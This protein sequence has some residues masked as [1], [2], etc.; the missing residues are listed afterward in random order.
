MK[1]AEIRLAE[2]R[3]SKKEFEHRLFKSLKDSRLEMREPEKVLR[4]V[5]D[6]SKVSKKTQIR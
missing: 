3:R 5:Q 2:I 1:E 4:Y 6:R